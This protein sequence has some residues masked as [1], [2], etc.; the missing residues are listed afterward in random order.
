MSPNDEWITFASAE[1]PTSDLFRY[2]LTNSALE[3]LTSDG[4][5]QEAPADWASTDDEIVYDED[6]SCS[7]C[8]LCTRIFLMNVDGTNSRQWTIFDSNSN[9]PRW[10][11]AGT[12]I[13][14][15]GGRSES[16]S[17][18]DEIWIVD[19]GTSNAVR[20]FTRP[21]Q[22]SSPAWSPDGTYL[23]FSGPEGTYRQIGRVEISTGMV[24]ILTSHSGNCYRPFWR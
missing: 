4:C 9:E 23:T 8:G 7:G 11:P 17:D 18:H 1:S 22:Q 14:F 16:G 20:V 24:T 19:R 6:T 12:Q 2:N 21:E 15:S 10:S 5:N 13:A 3:N